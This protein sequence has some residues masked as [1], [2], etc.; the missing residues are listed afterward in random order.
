M[1]HYNTEINT[2]HGCMHASMPKRNDQKSFLYRY[3]SKQ[4]HMLWDRGKRAHV[5]AFA[6]AWV[7]VC[8]I[9]IHIYTDWLVLY[10]P[11]LKHQVMPSSQSGSFHKIFIFFMVKHWNLS[12]FNLNRG[13][14][15]SLFGESP[16]S[17]IFR[18]HPG[19]MEAATEAAPSLLVDMLFKPT[20]NNNNFLSCN[21]R[22]IIAIYHQ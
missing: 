19:N 20:P 18:R 7:S 13:N 16:C 15:P 4:S 6:S 3:I 21:L 22:Y 12:W 14:S 9:A 8:E 1:R 2:C 5:C 10:I 17:G 11:G